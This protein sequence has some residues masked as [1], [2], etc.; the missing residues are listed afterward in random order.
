MERTV[1]LD[2]LSEFLMVE[3]GGLELYRV[4]AARCADAALKERYLAFGAETARHR[5]LLVRLIERLGG[6]PAYVS[7]TARRAQARAAALQQAPLATHGLSPAELE[8]ADLENVLLAET[9]DH[10]DWHLL[11]L[12]A[13]Q[14]EDPAVRAALEEIVPRVEEEEDEHLRWARDALAE[15]TLRRVQLGPAAPPE[16]SQGLL[17]GPE[18]PLT[19]IH[20]APA[21]EGLLPLSELP[22]WADP[23]ALRELRES[24]A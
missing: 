24:P 16:R 1:L 15:R 23:P 10:A 9:K 18:P 11:Q 6:D 3:Q 8:A 4:A 13:G 12:L 21:T 7:P 19:A 22:P 2:L 5:E 20:P 14:A 17:T